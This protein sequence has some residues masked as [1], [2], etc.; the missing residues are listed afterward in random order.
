MRANNSGGNLSSIEDSVLILKS[1]LRCQR[2]NRKWNKLANQSIIWQ[3]RI[4]RRK[5]LFN[6]L[7]A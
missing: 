2:I 3:V 1:I 5:F 6:S 7:F 4:R